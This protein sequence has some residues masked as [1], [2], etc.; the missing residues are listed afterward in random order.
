MSIN[1]YVTKT[2]QRIIQYDDETKESGIIY[3]PNGKMYS[4]GI[5]DGLCSGYG[6]LYFENKLIY[7]GQWKYNRMNG[8]GVYYFNNGDTYE[9]QIEDE[10]AHG[11]G[12]L[13]ILG[14]RFDMNYNRYGSFPV[15]LVHT[16]CY[17]LRL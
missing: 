17:G 16:S 3:Y 14:S 5:E 12:I 13:T 6:L 11:K 8:Q 15:K 1:K 2:K 7:Q 10:Y 9:G 4:G